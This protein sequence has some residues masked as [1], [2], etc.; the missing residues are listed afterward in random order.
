MGSPTSL[1]W[2]DP[3]LA[4]R[5][6][7]FATRRGLTVSA[8]IQLLTDEALRMREH[9]GIVFRDGPAGRRA[10]LAGGPDVWEV[11]RSLRQA[12]TTTGLGREE[13]VA[14]NTGLTLA[15]IRVAIGYY[16]AHAT[17]VDGQ[18]AEADATEEAALQ[19]WERRRR[20]L[21]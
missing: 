2:S 10:G 12:T 5:V 1:R 11:V 15:E 17:E 8:A 18:V 21:A 14:T 20:L 19:A 9:P 4:E 3:G 6:A 16:T 7:S 13:L